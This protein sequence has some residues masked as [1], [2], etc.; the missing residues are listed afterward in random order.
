MRSGQKDCGERGKDQIS[1]VSWK[2][3][4]KCISKIVI[5]CAECCILVKE[6][7]V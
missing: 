1:V 5:N 2:L 3:R 4:E 6:E 7:E